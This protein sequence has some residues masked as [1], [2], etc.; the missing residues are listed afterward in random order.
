MCACARGKGLG[1]PHCGRGVMRAYF[2]AATGADVDD[3][4]NGQ[5]LLLTFKKQLSLQWIF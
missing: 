3:L 2:I 1:A 4:L 5:A